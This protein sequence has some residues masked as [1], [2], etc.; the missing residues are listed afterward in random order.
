MTRQNPS[1]AQD[2]TPPETEHSADALTP[3]PPPAAPTDQDVG[4][5]TEMVFSGLQREHLT[6]APDYETFKTGV[7]SFDDEELYQDVE[8]PDDTPEAHTE[9][10]ITGD[11]RVSRDTVQQS[12]TGGSGQLV[13]APLE[14]PGDVGHY[15]AQSFDPKQHYSQRTATTNEPLALVMFGVLLLAAIGVFGTLAC[16]IYRLVAGL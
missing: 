6:D 11:H 14:T 1:D 4:L 5:A 13:D 7:L 2:H 9:L 16:L 10:R 15:E 3:P 8:S 12:Q